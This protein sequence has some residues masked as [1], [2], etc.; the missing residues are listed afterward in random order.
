[1]VAALDYVDKV[2]APRSRV[3]RDVIHNPAPGRPLTGAHNA[4]CDQIFRPR[5]S[6]AGAPR[7][8][9]TYMFEARHMRL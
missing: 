2:A 3:N 9:G 1:M 4:L 8:G 5:L 7:T 6:G